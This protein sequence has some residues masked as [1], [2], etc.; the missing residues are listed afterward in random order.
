MSR[1]RPAAAPPV[2][3]A[4]PPS[5]EQK[6]MSNADAA[7]PDAPAPA[8]TIV[9]PTIVDTAPASAAAPTPVATPIV[10]VPVAAAPAAAITTAERPVGP[11]TE[12]GQPPLED[13]VAGGHRAD[14]GVTVTLTR[15]QLAALDRLA[16]GPALAPLP[17]PLPEVRAS[18]TEDLGGRRYF[19]V[20]YD[21]DHDGERYTPAGKPVP[22]TAGEHERLRALGAVP[23]HWNE[24]L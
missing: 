8:A 11:I 2:K 3:P 20:A 21:V 12:S 6:L 23:S 1:R 7:R 17:E 4:I 5:E 10:D 19:R 18:A 9:E 24:G 14:E 16:A 22:L 15:G 13:Q